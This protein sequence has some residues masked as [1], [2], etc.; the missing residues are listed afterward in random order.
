MRLLFRAFR[1]WGLVKAQVDAIALERDLPL[2][3]QLPGRFRF[4]ICS[5]IPP[6]A[7]ARYAHSNTVVS[8]GRFPL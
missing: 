6:R 1:I 3:S 4:T 5:L 7:E 8:L 2:Y